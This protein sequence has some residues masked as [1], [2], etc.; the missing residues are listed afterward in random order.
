MTTEETPKLLE[1]SAAL[2]LLRKRE[3]LDAFLMDL[4]TPQERQA[5]QERWRVAQ[6]LARGDLSYREIHAIS[7]ASL[8][9][10]S[11]VAR[12]LK[13][14]PFQGYQLALQR[15]ASP[16]RKKEDAT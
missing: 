11:R 14:E 5:L 10:I 15:A 16:R 2:L 8:T 4:C 1:L 3:E 9:T 13:D 12:F 7:G 6:L